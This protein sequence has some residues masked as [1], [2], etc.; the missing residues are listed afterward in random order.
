MPAPPTFSLLAGYPSLIELTGSESSDREYRELDYDYL[1]HG[2]DHSHHPV[3]LGDPAT[4]DA[5]ILHLK[6]AMKLKAYFAPVIPEQLFPAIEH[7]PPNFVWKRYVSVLIPLGLRAKLSLLSADIVNAGD[8]PRLDFKNV[9]IRQ[10]ILEHVADAICRLD[11]FTPIIPVN[12][13]LKYGFYY[14]M[15]EVDPPAEAIASRSRGNPWLGR[16]REQQRADAMVFR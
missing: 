1:V 11:Y 14:E 6:L 2:C 5:I 13:M 7:L 16:L 3:D 15:V 8:F 10:Q 9:V 12:I 4:V